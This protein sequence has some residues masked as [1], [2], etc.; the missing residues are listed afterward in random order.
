MKE[1]YLKSE[2]YQISFSR[3]V[4]FNCGIKI[5]EY[6]SQPRENY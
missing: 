2:N 1:N 3:E 4:H 6:Y 5:A